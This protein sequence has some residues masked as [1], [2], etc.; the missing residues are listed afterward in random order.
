MARDTSRTSAASSARSSATR[1]ATSDITPDTPPAS[2]AELSAT[3]QDYLKSI[4]SLA[5][6]SEGPVATKALAERLSVR[7]STVSDAVRK[8]AVQGLVSH[9]RYGGI[10]LTP[11]GE[12]LALDMVRRHRLLEAFMVQALGYGWEEVHD[13]AEVLEHA[14]SD[15]FVDRVADYLGHPTH[16]PHG[17]PIPPPRAERALGADAEDS[18]AHDVEGRAAG[19]TLDATGAADSAAGS[20][21]KGSTRR[22]GTTRMPELPDGAVRLSEVDAGRRVTLER[23]AHADPQLLRFCAEHGLVHGALLEVEPAPPFVDGVTVRVLSPSPVDSVASMQAS[24]DAGSGAA[25]QVSAEA[26]AHASAPAIPSSDP[27]PEPFLLG[28]HAARRIWVT[29]LD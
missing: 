15:R 4:W 2:V 16:D 3:T 9:A 20:G 26:P 11:D 1:S 21:L 25:S 17:A 29:E 22:L 7:A 8:L 10:E 18:S 28:E 13:D 23:L 27:Q 5:Q 12:A 24:S 14:V 6:W 19:D